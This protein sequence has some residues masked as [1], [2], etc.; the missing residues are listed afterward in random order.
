MRYESSIFIDGREISITQPT[1]FI[2]DIA[3]NHDGS[4][5]R[6]KKLIWLAKESSADAVKFQHFVA[7]KFVSDYGFKSLGKKKSHQA[8]WEKDVYT[9]HVKCECDRRWTE[10]L[11]AEAK[12][13][14]IT[15]FTTP[16]DYEAVTAWNQYASAYKIGS[17]DI[18]WT[19]LIEKIS[20]RGVPVLLSTGASTVEDVHRSVDTI[21]NY[22]K[23][24]VLLQC[25]TNY[26]GKQDNFKYLNLN[27]LKTFSVMY[28]GMILGF[29]DHTPLHAAVLGA[30]A[31]GARVVEKHFTDD[32]A[33]KGPDHSFAMDSKSWK[34]MVVRSREL[35]QALGDGVKRVEGN[36]Q[37][38][39][40]LQQRSLRLTRDIKAGQL[41]SKGDFEYLRPAPKDAVKPFH[42][43]MVIGKKL[44]KD[45]EKGDAILIED[46]A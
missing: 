27:A 4:L 2:A 45:K 24:I 29:S 36:E 42:A 9:T 22:N 21:L 34:E 1:Y 32:N 26:T 11:I 3:S 37:E 15:I 18:T 40:V 12:K 31:L 8:S 25:N 43:A 33:R 10:E 5:D 7:D 41:I 16:Y 17:G 6:A 39:V 38:T 28:P 13:A 19:G 46:V 30:I 44:V 35:E 23:N 14:E 20:K